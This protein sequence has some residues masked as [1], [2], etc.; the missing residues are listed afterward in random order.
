MSGRRLVR[1]F[2]L[3]N[4]VL[5]PGTT[6]P[7][8]VFEPRYRRMLA[9]ALDSDRLIGMQL[10]KPGDSGAGERPAVYSIGCAGEVVHHEPLEDGR[11]NILLRGAFRYRIDSEPPTDTPYRI[12]EITPIAIA[13]LPP[14]DGAGRT[15][16]DL[17]RALA[18]R[19]RRLADGVGRAAARELPV[20]LSDEGLVNEAIGRL[21]LEPE[22]AYQLLAMDR[23]EER[24]EWTLAHIEGVQRRLDFLSPFRRPAGDPRWN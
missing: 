9:D 18:D 3:P 4:V 12:A 1:L 21:G 11:S 10:L 2:P 24:Y 6:I 5:L 16:R 8:H 14:A 20:R 15:P 17:R 13:P 23:L 22:E 7:L 19:L